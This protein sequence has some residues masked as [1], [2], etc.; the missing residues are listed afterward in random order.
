MSVPGEGRTAVG[1]E[2]LVVIERGIVGWAMREDDV[3][4]VTVVGSRAR[5]DPPADDWSD[6]DLMIYARTPARLLSDTDWLATIWPV[7]VSV[8]FLTAG[9]EPELLVLFAGGHD[10]DLVINPVASLVDMA[11]RGVLPPGHRRGARVLVD[12]DDLVSHTLP[13]S[14]GP[15]N[16]PLP[17]AAEYS[18]QVAGFW[19]GAHYVAK[20]IR[21]GDLWVVK[22]RDAELK[23]AVL[24][25]TEWHARAANP[26]VDT[27]HMGRFLERWADPRVVAALSGA[28]GRFDVADSWAALLATMDLF[29]WIARETAERLGFAVRFELSGV[30]TELVHRLRAEDSRVATSSGRPAVS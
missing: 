26:S 17:S 21:R 27:W 23:G 1:A 30:V 15:P 24:R 7:W 2:P 18:A 19:Y 11:E 16:G 8:P 25:M 5:A 20:Q 9:D 3:R 29:T 14:F 10:V 12:K 6:L 4:A 22:I 28:F 13:S